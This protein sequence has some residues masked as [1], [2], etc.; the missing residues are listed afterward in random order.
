MRINLFFLIIAV[1]L[2][3]SC[4]T[5]QLQPEID[6]ALKETKSEKK[7]IPAQVLADLMPQLEQ[8]SSTEQVAEQRFDIDAQNVEIG[9]FF[10]SLVTGTQLNVILH[11][12][13][14][15]E[16]SLTLKGVTLKEVVE[17][18]SDMYGYDIKLKGRILQI[19]PAGLRTETISV[20]YLAMQRSG[21]SY[22]SI[23]SGGVSNASNGNQQSSGGSS[24]GQNSNSNLGLTG[25]NANNSSSDFGSSNISNGT[26]IVSG[27]NN[28][29][30]KDLKQALTT[31][32]GDS[33]NRSIIVNPQAGLVT[34]RAFPDEIRN[35]K[36]FLAATEEQ[37]Q[38]QV[39]LEVKVIEVSLNDDYQQGIEWQTILGPQ[40]NTTVLSGR[41][42]GSI[43][44][45]VSSV[46]GGVTSITVNRS[47]FTGLV[48]LL[49]TQGDAQVL[50]SPRLTA[51]NNQKAVIK[52]GTDEYFVTE[53]STTTVTGTATTSSPNIELEPFFSGIAL[54]VTPQI[55]E[56]G[57]V[58]L[59]VHPSVI[60]TSEQ[61]KV[62]TL[63]QQD[64]TL[65][66]A[67]SNVR[68]SDTIIRANSGEIVVIG[69]L[70]QTLTSKV[71]ASTPLLGDIPYL[72]E[73]FKSKTE[74]SLKKELIIMIKPT[75][76]GA[77]TWQEQL[78]RS[79]DLLDKWYK[80]E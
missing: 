43:Q 27:S 73:L 61:I 16:I 55:D 10:Q 66:L 24:R 12:N 30:W 32:I 13:T 2:L 49:Q 37:M 41:S 26:T 22:T 8:M 60:D 58:T 34:V 29:F 40:N 46:L 18:I 35:I 78:K 74:K 59:H 53:V 20:N 69:G 44:N 68:E 38:R 14:S 67:Q 5:T 56:N 65:P 80:S 77:G 23:T 52:V 1:N 36:E 17:L 79:S 50:S 51:S 72:G 33:E 31:L 4:Q 21:A 28:D 47:D 45:A 48:Q 7:K 11:P 70:M 76:V 63:N 71:D 3:A 39:I 54:D 19:Y 75:V 9:A 42:G 25:Q 57:S 6:S 15:G 64:F 62:V